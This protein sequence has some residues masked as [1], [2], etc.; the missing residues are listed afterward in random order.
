M[1]ATITLKV[2]IEVMCTEPESFTN[3]K[4][5]HREDLA[6]FKKYAAEKIEQALPIGTWQFSAKA[7][8][9]NVK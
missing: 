7:I 5:F 3:L 4:Q 9:V 1:K 2:E 8:D 6:A